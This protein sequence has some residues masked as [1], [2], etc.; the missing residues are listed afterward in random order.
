MECA[1]CGRANPPGA[2]FCARCGRALAPRCPACN[3]ETLPDAQF[4]NACGA[5]LAARP[6]DD[7]A[8]RKVVTIVFA[9]LVGSTALH[10]RLDAESVRRFMDDYYVAMRGAVEAHGGTVTQLLGDGVKAVFGA[11]RVAEDDAI[12]AVRAA[13]AM[14]RA[15]RALVSESSA[16]IGATG[17][18]V[19]VNTGEVIASEGSEIIGDPVN[20]A[21]RLQE[22]ARDGDVVIGEATR[23]IVGELVTLAPMGAFALKGRS[24]KVTAWRVASLERPVGASATPFVGRES[25]LRRILS[26]YDGA[27]FDERARLAA[28]LGSPGLGKSRVIGEVAR[29]LGGQ[30]TVLLA[31]CE[32]AGGTT[33]APIA[34][35]LRAQLALDVGASA[36]A[37]QAALDAVLRDGE[38]EPARIASGIRALLAG[39]PAPPEETFFAVR[40]YLTALA[41]QQPVVLAIDDLQWAEPLLLDLTEHLVQ[42]ATDVPLF[43]LIAA[44]PEL[45]D[46]RSS[47][48]ATGPLVAEVVTLAGLDAGAATRL[49]ANVIGAED[50]PAAVAVRV[51]ATSEGNPLFLG[52]LVRMLVQDGALKREGDRWTASA[53]L[54]QLEMPPTI[55][56][57]LAARIERLSPEERTVL[58][59][60][61]VIGRQFSRAAVT[62]LLPRDLADLDR[63]LEALRRSELVEPDTGWFLG[64]PA[65]RFHHV[66]IRDAAYR[67]LLKNKRAEL[68]E[69]FADW[70]ASRVSDAAEHDE[71]L[72]WHLE[73]A[74]AHLG[75]LGPLDEHGRALGERASRHL[76]AA[77]RR[78]L[79]R[80][81]VPLAASLIGRAIDRLE[82]GDALRADLALD[83]CEALLAAGEV[84]TAA[85]AIDELGRFAADSER[86]RAW[87]T[88]FIGE[89]AS[90]TDPQALRATADTVA[91]AADQLAAAGD[92]AG[93]AMA[94][95]VHARA[96]AQLGRVG[97]CEAALDRALAAARR[98][99]DRRRANAV[100]AGA[101]LAALWGPSPVTR[102][103]GRCLDVVRVLRITQGAP[104]VE[105]VA[106]RCQGVLESLRGR[107]EAARRMIATSRRM[108]EELGITHRLL[109]AD[110]FAGHIELIEG[111]PAAAER[112]LR[113]AYEGLRELGHGII[114]AQ[115]AALLGRALLAQGRAEE[116]EALSHESEKLA[117]DELKGAISWRSVRAEALARRGDAAA[118]VELARA[119]VELAAA[120]DALLDHADAR[121]ALGAA[122]RAAGRVAEADAE[123]RRAVELWEAK[124][125]TLLAERARNEGARVVPVERTAPVAAVAPAARARVPENYATLHLKRLDAAVAARDFQTVTW[126]LSESGAIDHAS[127][128]SLS[129]DEHHEL[130]RWNVERFAGRALRNETIAALGPSLA[131][132]RWREAGASLVGEDLPLG[133]FESE[134]WVL[135][136]ADSDA[137]STHVESFAPD[138]LGDA[139]VRLYER[140]AELQP[141]G[142]ERTRAAATARSVATLAR[143]PAHR[144]PFAPGVEA[145]DQRIVGFGFLRGAES[146]VRATRAFFE[147]TD[148]FE[149]RTD[150]VLGLRSDTLLVRRTNSGTDRASGGEFERT[151][152]HR[153]VFDADGLVTRWEQFDTD[154]AADALARFDARTAAPAPARRRVRPNAATD[155]GARNTAALSAR[156][157][158]ALRRSLSDNFRATNHQNGVDLDLEEVLNWWQRFFSEDLG[159]S[160]HMEPVASL[161]DSLALFT[162]SWTGPG[163]AN[164]AGAFEQ[165]NFDLVQTDAH[166]AAERIEVFAGDHLGDAV[167]RLYERYAELLPAGPGRERAAAIARSISGTE[168]PYDL[169]RF[170]TFH[171]PSFEAIDHRTLGT[172]SARGSADALRN[173]RAWFDLATDLTVRWDDILG[174]APDAFLRRQTLHGTDRLGGGSFEREFLILHVYGADGLV[175][176]SEY[177]DVDRETDALGRYDELTR[178]RPPSARRRVRPNAATALASRRDAAIAARDSDGL[179]A[180]VADEF[181]GPDHSTGAT[182]DREGLIFSLRS[183]LRARDPTSHHEPL[184]TLGDSLA[185][186]RVSTSGSGFS[187]A[188]F[189]VG[190][191]EREEIPLIEVDAQGR[192]RRHEVFSTDHLGDA[193]VRLYERHAELLPEGPERERAAAVARSMAIRVHPVGRERYGDTL[194]PNVAF[195]DHR[196]VV[197]NLSAQGNAVF[198]FLRATF[199]LAAD[200]ATCVDDI[201]ALEPSAVLTRI[202]QTGTGRASGGAFESKRLH[203]WVFGADGLVSH[204]EWFDTDRDADALARFDALTAEPP[205]RPARRLRPNAATLNQARTDAAIA[206]R[207]L[208]AAAQL[209]SDGLEYLHH[210]T[211]ATFDRDGVVYSLR[212]LLAAESPSRRHEPLATLGDA[213][214]LCRLTFGASGFSGDTF[215]V[216]AYEIEELELSELDAQGRRRRVEAFAADRLGDAVVRL[217]ERYAERLP[218]GPERMR[219]AA[220]A[221]G[222]AGWRAG[223]FDLDRQEA[224][225]APTVE[226]VD[227]RILGTWSARGKEAVLEHFRALVEVADD[228]R[229]RDED[230]L[231]SR[232]DALLVH[233][234]HLGTDRASGGA[235][236]RP[237]LQLWVFGSD[238]LTTRIEWF[239]ADSEA[240]ALARF[241]ALTAETAPAPRIETAAT[242][243]VDRFVRAWTARDW[244]AITDLVAP[245]NETSDRRSLVRLELDHD[246]PLDFQGSLF[247]MRSSCNEVEVL[248]TRGDRLAL[249]RTRFEVADDLIGESEIA[250][251]AVTEVDRDGRQIWAVRFDLEALDAAYAEL[252]AR[253][254]AGEAAAHPDAQRAVQAFQRANA[255]G[256][257]ETLVSLLVRDLILADHRVLGWGTLRSRVEILA[258]MRSRFDLRPDTRL[259]VNHVVLSDRAVLTAFC[260]TGS[261]AEGAYE[262]PLIEVGALG[263]DGRITR[264]DVYDLDQLDAA[265]ARFAELSS[266]PR[267]RVRPNAVTVL[268]ARLDAAVAA[269][270]VGAL[271]MLLSES[272]EEVDHTTGATLDREAMLVSWRTLL[273]AR[274][275]IHRCVPL[276]T[277]GDSLALSRTFA[278]ASGFSGRT[279]DVGAYELEQL[280]VTEA[281]PQGI[282]WTEIFGPN[283]L[284]NAVGRLYERY[285][286][287]LP[288]GPERDSAA[289]IARSLAVLL[290]LPAFARWPLAPEIE[291]A[292]RRAMG[293][294]ALRGAEAVRRGIGAYLEGLENFSVRVDDVLGAR[295]D[296]LL[297]RGATTGALRNSGAEFER[298]I[299][300]LWVFGADGQ[301]VRWEQFDGDRE[302]DALARF[303][304]LAPVPAVPGVAR[305]ENAATHHLEEF[306]A[307]WNA[308]DWRRIEAGYA[309]GFQRFDRRKLILLDLDR[310]QHLQWAR[311]SFEMSASRMAI[312]VRATRGDRLA[313]AKFLITASDGDFGATEVEFLSVVELDD[314]GA[315]TAHVSFDPDDLDAAYAEL[316]AR[317]AAGEGAAHPGIGGSLARL[318]QA[319]STRDWE[320]WASVFSPDLAIQDHRSL[321]LYEGSSRDDWVATDRALQEL[322]PDATLRVDH[323][324]LSGRAAISVINWTGS[325]AEGAFEI[326]AAVVLAS[327]TDGRIDR[328]YLYD[329]DQLDL[330]RA[331]FE[332]LR[333]PDP[334]A[335]PPNAATRATDRYERCLADR[336]WDALRALCAPEMVFDD[337][338]RMIR[339]TV[340][341]EAFVAGAKLIAVGETRLSRTLLATAGDRLA[342]ERFLWWRDDRG[343]DRGP[344]EVEQLALH[345]VDADGRYV[346]AISFD[347]DDRRA[348]SLELCDRRAQSLPGKLFELRRAVIEHDL[349]RIRSAIPDDFVFDDHRRTGLGRVEGAD[350]YVAAMAALFEQSPDAI[351]EALYEVAV[352]RYGVLTSLTPSARSLTAEVRSSRSMCTSRTSRQTVS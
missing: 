9:D 349:V 87:H 322:R 93:E 203:L 273:A 280:Y 296:A 124:G 140:Y 229:L 225:L 263:T 43:V 265:R 206:A 249:C 153:W 115:A 84:G 101:P 335:I 88:C 285:A 325:E 236:E 243:F 314:S 311:T 201:L 143:E 269:R 202:T 275:P 174:V 347:A 94:H 15:F 112:C 157:F 21:A 298:P 240:E 250:Y 151:L 141:E 287:R 348:A 299:C 53:D 100:L 137:R 266:A 68:H 162:R 301:L 218:E 16:A 194:S 281:D 246:Q 176:R 146:V 345:E 138:K 300:Q 184:A 341:R 6:A 58:E 110:V 282:R 228:I 24:E 158:D 44:R 208:D 337:R 105:A 109:E 65:L 30:A 129:V 86:L 264:L 226:A 272:C 304:A 62:A 274:D 114:A 302:A 136:D 130:F 352:E 97:A 289:A 72:G 231:G 336:D 193:I 267:R 175:L 67:R 83:W 99:G 261:E 197:G 199:E 205:A 258:V 133:P 207:D 121:T 55:Q 245:G 332:E 47:L 122:L 119:A 102:A 2:R 190:A 12:R 340:D 257:T 111:D 169:D 313:L 232:P 42:W 178:E 71:T 48:A 32:S 209:L 135:I 331:R 191:Y 104:A 118:A 346:A 56:A 4:C 18:R 139:I 167:A 125:A 165:K 163:S 295:P 59:R 120:S 260:W 108:V 343:V 292:D 338:R 262:T 241:D 198:D 82:T 211:G 224:A 288:A 278:S 13:V 312:K 123:E 244:S 309:P 63:Q 17:L 212:S 200:M 230:V 315:S 286:E 27:V 64:E 22:E 293:V 235:Y 342:L 234:T 85:T 161:G 242:R 344:F 213:L 52:E 294:G 177:F 284:G 195:I 320:R 19:A 11:P 233:R 79:A 279:F 227:H 306:A 76:A 159:A 77:G 50:L 259:R 8:L 154:R 248:A 290:G 333:R 23:R 5:A 142:P 318:Q 351:L 308:H 297:V 26:V 256:E 216:G 69:R 106:L 180:L 255:A 268:L 49:A 217:Y 196:S 54:A 334:L 116:A 96:L 252:D 283:R 182:L 25:E 148:L 166:G 73:Q 57:L 254:A 70:V 221:R 188:T 350:A 36:E 181:E 145:S 3:A 277:L 39:T 164:E 134:G 98:G 33:F 189:D 321:R 91:A 92:A 144:W 271:P 29:R 160:F 128:R 34:E 60:A 107:S 310:D 210:P 74:H 35:A 10:E 7:A 131:L 126:L 179:A 95:F 37:V 78:A 305:I 307:A 339:L 28:V 150:D 187:G 75:E 81:D 239:D 319:L 192:E 326:P 127:G 20:V 330:A 89:R 173:M 103:S 323:L 215:D 276:A 291:Y 237:F 303:D 324:E 219:A 31:R 168:G 14:Q 117:G 1:S 172:Q 247:E 90:L 113:P 253:Y 328:V 223:A 317:Y 41:K 45:R 147:L 80:D 214:A 152:I 155:F 327:R 171:A 316:D 183:L 270:D 61:A 204:V 46:A 132:A 185:L 251:L 149:W 220:T 66:L 222:V 186:L 40:R 238:G 156:D 170:T 38:A 51:L 329:L